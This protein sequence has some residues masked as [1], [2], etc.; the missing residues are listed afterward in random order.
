[1]DAVGD[2]E[3][4]K[5]RDRCFVC[6][7]VL[8]GTNLGG[9]SGFSFGDLVVSEKSVIKPSSGDLGF[10]ELG[11]WSMRAIKLRI[12]S[13]AFSTKVSIGMSIWR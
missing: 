1:M 10:N 13:C 5:A 11:E 12:A 2:Q 4:I 8:N 7:I 3:P 6:C 9:K